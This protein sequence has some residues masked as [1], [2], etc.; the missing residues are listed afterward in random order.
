VTATVDLPTKSYSDTRA[1]FAFYKQV[2][3]RL[4]QLPGVEHAASVSVLP[5][6]GDR[7]IDMI[8]V[9]GD[10]RPFM[11]LPSEHSAV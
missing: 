4:A 11:Q 1:R 6:S 2:L 5:L 9:D 3:A 10:G 7:W 8:R